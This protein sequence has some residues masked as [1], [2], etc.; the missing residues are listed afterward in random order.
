[1][2]CKY[3]FDETSSMDYDV[4][5]IG[6]GPAGCIAA[7]YA[8]KH[9]STLVVE[10]HTRI[11]EP[12]Q[13]A[14]LISVRAAAESELR[15]KFRKCVC[16][17]V[18][19]AV[20]HPPTFRPLTVE[21]RE[22]KA[23]VIRRDVFDRLLAEE[24]ARSGADFLMQSKVVGIKRGSESP[25]ELKIICEGKEL[26]I[27]AKV[28]VG[29]DGASGITQRALGLRIRRLLSCVQVCGVYE[30][31]TNFVELFFGRSIAPGFFA[32]AIP[33]GEGVARLGLCVDVT[34]GGEPLRRLDLFLKRL[35]KE[36]KF[37]GSSFDFLTGI[38]PLGPPK[39][40]AA[41]SIMLLGDAAAQV[42]PV[43][44]GGVYY[45]MKCGKLAGMLAAEAAGVKA[46]AREKVVSRY[47]GM[48][49]REIGREIGFGMLLHR[50][51]CKMG[52]K[53][54]DRIFRVLDDERLLKMVEEKGDMDYQSSAL[55]PMLWRLL[56]HPKTAVPLFLSL[57][58]SQ[59]KSS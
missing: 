37:K 12:A 44:G 48:W 17:E 49:R 59:L 29:A 38:I 10:E 3:E 16:N 11:G 23:F 40:T 15:S 4:V 32:W 6:G 36:G 57:A 43:T 22:K 41:A 20:F 53:D 42:K 27:T 58:R 50:L 13:C 51:R 33:V 14:G 47:D 34:V 26:K 18:S 55:L 19:G 35:R 21:G 54:L 9:V 28:V 39:L 1:M 8:A 25:N 30:C 5:V 56:M 7:K 45:G 52:D 24:A 2:S 46:A 31:D